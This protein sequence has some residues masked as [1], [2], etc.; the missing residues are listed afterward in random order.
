MNFPIEF[1]FLNILG[2]I[3]LGRMSLN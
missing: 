3:I 1:Y 2:F